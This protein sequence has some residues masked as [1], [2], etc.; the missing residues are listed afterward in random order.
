MRWFVYIQKREQDTL[1]MKI[2]EW[3]TAGS[4]SRGWPKTSPQGPKK[5]EHYG[6]ERKTNMMKTFLTGIFPIL[7]Y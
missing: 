1:I 6:L 4:K 3:K 5:N 7:I 2:I